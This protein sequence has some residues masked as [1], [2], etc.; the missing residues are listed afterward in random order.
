MEPGNAT[1]IRSA[2][3]K[4]TSTA[5]SEYTFHFS[6]YP[7]HE[8]ISFF[9]G[10]FK[11]AGDNK[12]RHYHKLMTEIFTVLQGEFFFSLADEEYVIQPGDTIIIPPLTIHGFRAKLPDSRLQI[13]SSNILNREEFFE[14]LAKI[15]N[16]ETLFNEEELEAFYNR[17][18][19]YSVK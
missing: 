14:G 8:N 6:S 7:A 4:G 10:H 19:Q 11:K 9:E 2:G 1:I 5:N 16:G 13:I 12:A 3:K 15:V 17:H 18:D